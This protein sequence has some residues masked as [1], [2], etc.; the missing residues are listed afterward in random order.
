MY[1]ADAEDRLKTWLDA[2]LDLYSR[3]SARFTDH[4]DDEVPGASNHNLAIREENRLRWEALGKRLDAIEE[5]VERLDPTPTATSTPMS[6][7]PPA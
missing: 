3:K 1:D 6:T 4:G 5:T 7:E 2:K